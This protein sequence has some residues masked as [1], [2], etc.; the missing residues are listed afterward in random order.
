MNLTPMKTTPC[1][2]QMPWG[3]TSLN[4]Q[5]GKHSE[6]PI[7]GESWEAADHFHGKTPIVGGCYDG[8]DFSQIIEEMG[9]DTFLGHLTTDGRF[10]LLFKLIDARDRLSVQVHPNDAFAAADG[11]RG[12]TEMW[13]VLEA[14]P[15][16]GLYL[17]F[18]HAISR[19]TYQQLIETNE[20][21]SALHFVP[22]KAGDTFFLPPGLVHA[23]GA[24]LV[25]AEIQQSSDATYRVYDWG[26]LGL[27]GK[28]RQLHIEKAL[29]VTDTALRGDCNAPLTVRE[30]GAEIDY[31]KACPLFAA[32]RIRLSNR[33]RM[34]TRGS[35]FTILFCAEGQMT[36]ST[37]DGAVQLEKGQTAVI[38][39]AANAFEMQGAAE[40]YRFFVPEPE[41]DFVEPLRK[42]GFTDAD[43]Q[44][45]L[46]G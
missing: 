42:A 20:L 30:D 21:E 3:G 40:V 33:C 27:D 38:P 2:K 28:P 41:R 11:D 37:A 10:P 19:E 23:I 12:K 32:Q 26:R 6:F 31:L 44:P 22:A 5:Y 4:E 45:L 35:S 36:V 18:E 8:K 15:G 46:H 7:T 25:I 1:Y 14:Q 43:I 13:I 39:A 16:A 24:G 9:A 34:E 29:A 17:G